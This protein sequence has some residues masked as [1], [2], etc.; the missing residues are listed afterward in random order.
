MCLHHDSD[1][2]L[3]QVLWRRWHLSWTLREDRGGISDKESG[4][5]VGVSVGFGGANTRGTMA[6]R[7]WVAVVALRH[8]RHRNELHSSHLHPVSYST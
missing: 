7:S 5:E 8:H 3:S 4:T 2:K 6:V 1:Q